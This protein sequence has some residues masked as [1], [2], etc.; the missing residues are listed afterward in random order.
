MKAA[1]A[2]G[3]LL[4]LMVGGRPV[5]ADEATAAFIANVAR[6]QATLD[7]MQ[8]L[9]TRMD[10]RRAAAAAASTT[11]ANPPAADQSR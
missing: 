4:G 2:L 10:Q 9:F 6:A 1:V 3:L 11:P 5:M 7:E 8:A